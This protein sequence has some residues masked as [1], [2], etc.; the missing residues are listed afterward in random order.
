MSM[1]YV[2]LQKKVDKVGTSGALRGVKVLR[3]RNR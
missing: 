1:N 2:N 3:P